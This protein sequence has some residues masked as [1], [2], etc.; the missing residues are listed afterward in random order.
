MLPGSSSH[1]DFEDRRDNNN[2]GTVVGNNEG[3]EVGCDDGSDDGCG[4]DSD[5]DSD[6]CKPL[7]LLTLHIFWQ[8]SYIF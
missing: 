4:D 2:N 8:L 5:D 7:H 3:W 1:S 6:V